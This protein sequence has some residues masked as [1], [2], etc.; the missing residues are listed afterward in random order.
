MKAG[1]NNNAAICPTNSQVGYALISMGA[2]YFGVPIFN[3]GASG[4]HPAV[5]GFTFLGAV[6]RLVPTVRAGD[7]GITMD[8][9]AVSQGAKIAGATITLWGIPQDPAN[10]PYRVAP[11]GQLTCVVLPTCFGGGAVNTDPPTPFLS[12]PTSCA[13]EPLRFD[14]LVDGWQSQGDFTERS[15][16]ADE[17]DVPFA[18]TGCD[19]LPFNAG[20]EVKATSGVADSPSG[21]DVELSV[22][23]NRVPDGLAA[24]HV[25]DVEMVLPDGLT[26]SPS[27]AAGLGAC[28]SA[29]IDL[30]SEGPHDCPRSSKLGT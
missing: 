19:R 29:Q 4:H 21:L 5:F 6:V 26:V 1:A 25:K 16:T 15:I 7:Y 24:A 9:G 11:G 27:S 12:L 14:L 20:A 13:A 8:S 30:A 3:L 23:Q 17:N 2:A 10:D 28:S 22:T 18:L